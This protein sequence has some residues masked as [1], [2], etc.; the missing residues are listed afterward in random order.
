MDVRRGERTSGRPCSPTD[1][2]Q[3]GMQGRDGCNAMEPMDD[4]PSRAYSCPNAVTGKPLARACYTPPSHSPEERVDSANDYSR[5]NIDCVRCRSIAIIDILVF[6]NWATPA[7]T[8]FRFPL[9]HSDRTDL[10]PR[11]VVCT[12]A[13]R[14]AP[15]KRMEPPSL[16]NQPSLGAHHDLYTSCLSRPDFR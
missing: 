5:C 16:P 9:S 11:S 1:D 12:D 2:H 10:C 14:G 4:Y 3:Q 7:E 13:F 6:N 15:A 8:C